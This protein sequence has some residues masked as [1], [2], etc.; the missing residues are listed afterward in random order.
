MAYELALRIASGSGFLITLYF[1]AISRRWIRDEKW[2]PGFVCQDHAC[3]HILAT[4]FAKF[5]GVSNFF[6]GMSYYAIVFGATFF[7]TTWFQLLFLAVSWL[8]VAYSLYLAHAL[9]FR[10]KVICRLCFASHI[11][12]ISIAVIYALL[13][14]P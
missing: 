3:I 4:K 14:V 12:N 9:L 10:L 11:I 6:W 7:D 13:A 1:I 2:I 8:V 5:L